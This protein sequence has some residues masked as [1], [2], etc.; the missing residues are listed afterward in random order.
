MLVVTQHAL[1]RAM[2]RLGLEKRE[3]RSKLTWLYGLSRIVVPR[4]LPAWFRRSHR[5]HPDSLYHL[6]SYL[7]QQLVL[8][9]IHREY[10]SV[11]TTVVTQHPSTTDPT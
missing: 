9:E 11:L 6:A 8:V 5:E 4:A 7:G 10:G 1:K 2:S 3:A